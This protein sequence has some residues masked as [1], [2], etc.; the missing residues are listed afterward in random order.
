VTNAQSLPLQ[1]LKNSSFAA[2]CPFIVVVP[3]CPWECA[4]ANRWLP[5]TL[6][7]VT[8]LITGHILP[9]LGGDPGRVYLAGQSMG[10]HGAWT[11]AAQQRGLFAAVAVVCGYAHSSEAEAIAHRLRG[12]AVCIAHA[13]D[14]SV[15]PVHASDMMVQQ[16]RAL[17]NM[18]MLVLRY[19]H[20][21]G[22]PMPEFAHL[23]G[24]GSYELVFKDSSFY[25]WLLRHHCKACG[26]KEAVWEELAT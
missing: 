9:N 23:I 16:L 18:D 21:P 2:Q 7:A 4:E 6:Q 3:Q 13:A 20:A 25:S 10:G 11:Y 17:G 14:D 1:L 24:H 5:T 8:S 26:P 19:D 22:P 15:I 12:A